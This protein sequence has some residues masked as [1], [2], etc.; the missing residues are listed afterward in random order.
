MTRGSLVSVIYSKTIRMGVGAATGSEAT[1]LM[2]ADVERIAVGMRSLHEVW[3]GVL[4][5][6]IG[7]WLLYR[8]VGLAMLSMAAMTLGIYIHPILYFLY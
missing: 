1:T 3:G 8:Q 7:L 4:D 2:S 6:G 5:L